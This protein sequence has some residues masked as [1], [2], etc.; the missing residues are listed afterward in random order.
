MGNLLVKELRT[1]KP[2]N[3]L[4]IN[5]EK[6][7]VKREKLD[8]WKSLGLKIKTWFLMYK[9]IMCRYVTIV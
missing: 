9:E 2:D 5:R 8:M 3:L 4:V 1:I 7:M 6:Q